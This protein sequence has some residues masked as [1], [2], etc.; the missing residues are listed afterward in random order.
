MMANTLNKPIEELQEQAQEQIKETKPQKVETVDNK[1][2]EAASV[3]RFWYFLTREPGS[4]EVRPDWYRQVCEQCGEVFIYSYHIKG[5][6]LCG[7]PCMIGKLR[8]KGLEYDPNV[9]F[10][11]RWGK[12]APAIV[13]PAALK[14]LQHLLSDTQEAP[15]DNTSDE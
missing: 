11:Q 5:V 10:K 2:H 9:P 4:E 12:Y 6:S 15:P 3:L 14:I 7:L 13:P 1:I 8:S